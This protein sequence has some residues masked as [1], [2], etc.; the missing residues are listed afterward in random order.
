MTSTNAQAVINAL[1]SI[2]AMFGDPQ[3][4]VSDNG[5]P[6]SSFEFE[7]FCMDADIQLIHSPAYHPQSNGTA[8]RFVQTVKQLLKKELENVYSPRVLAK[9]L[10]SIRN[11]PSVNGK[12]PSELVFSF[13]PCTT[14]EKIVREKS[15]S[16]SVIDLDIP[17]HRN[18]VVGQKV[19]VLG[20]RKGTPR[21][22]G[23]ILGK[24]GNLVYQVRLENGVI[25]NSHA[26]QMVACQIN[27]QNKIVTPQ[28]DLQDEIGTRR[29]TRVKKPIVRL[30][31]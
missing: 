27:S 1:V 17:S 28:V 13:T 3:T 24:I 14:L 9:V 22:L 6:F 15:L 7:K 2:F 16:N 5:P 29:S 26:N 19:F 12:T 30:N 21:V 8:E 20:E 4:L 23:T 31:L 25:R 11:T 10:S 18:F